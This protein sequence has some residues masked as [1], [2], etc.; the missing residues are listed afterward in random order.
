[1]T[2]PQ[3][4]PAP[5]RP[6]GGA[7]PGRA[8]ARG[9]SRFAERHAARFAADYF[10]S[11]TVSHLQ[12]SSLGL[13]T[14][15]GE[16]DADDDRDYAETAHLAIA[17]G[18]SLLDTAINYRCQRS[19]RAVGRA[20]SRAIREGAAARDEIVV[21]TK[22][23]YIPLDDVPPP[24][25]ED[26][27]AYVEREY[28]ATGVARPDDVV[29]GGHCI[30]P[31]FL[32][33]QIERSLANLGVETIDVYYVHNPEQQLDA[34][35]P[36]QL[37]AR[38]RA[39]FELL[40]HQCDAGTIGAYGCATWNGLRVAPGSRGHLNLA[41]LVSIARDICGDRH[42]FAVVQL[43]LNLAC[44][45]AVRLPT[46]TLGTHTVPVLEAAAELGVAVVASAALLQ[47]KLAHNLPATVHDA[48]PGFAT[49][50]QRAIAFVRSLPMVTAALVGTKSARH[51]HE[52]L[53]AARR[54]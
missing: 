24:T 52:N 25:R 34:I 46:Q 53:A 6:P 51:L 32:A 41:D 18:V 36:D 45:E 42:H 14:Y 11:F 47:G 29:A 37:A 5:S 2:K 3:R 7:I 31:S 23:G 1:M 13:G 44:T 20:L 17:S 54:G 35:T 50:A 27:Q 39:A 48:L 28:Y 43:P 8:T 49:D 38:L 33:A 30:A 16:C 22:G 26:Y 4:R 15:L 10:R 40:E 21:C 12:V 19:E 9:T